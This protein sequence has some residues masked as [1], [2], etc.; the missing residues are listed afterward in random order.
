M[1]LINIGRCFNVTSWSS[2]WLAEKAQPRRD[3]ELRCEIGQQGRKT[4]LGVK[5]GGGFSFA[6][7]TDIRDNGQY[8]KTPPNSINGGNVIF[9]M[10]LAIQTMGTDWEYFVGVKGEVEVPLKISL[11]NEPG[12]N[13]CKLKMQVTLEP[14]N[15]SV[16]ARIAGSETKP[17]PLNI[18]TPDEN[19][20]GILLEYCLTNP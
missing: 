2:R 10:T 20:D 18:Y 17:Y 14:I 7:D 13:G 11:F 16:N 19:Y 8:A 6:Y 9:A 4:K 5:V 1:R 15:L 12:V 3:V